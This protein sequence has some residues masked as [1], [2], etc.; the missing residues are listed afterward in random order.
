MWRLPDSPRWLISKSK[1][2]QARRV[3]QRV[4]TASD[5][6]PEITDIQQSMDTAEGDGGMAGL[7]Q[8]SLRMPMI[9]G[10][11][12]AVFQQITGINT[13]IYYAPT[14]FK[15]AGIHAA[16]S[17]DPGR[18]GVGHGDVVLSRAGH[19]PAGPRRKEAF[20]IGR[21][22]W[23]DYWPGDLWALAFQ[24]QQLASFKSDD[25]H[26]RPGDLCRLF[27]FWTRADLLADDF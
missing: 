22:C 24:F 23:S 11:G 16:G 27:R 6:S 8:P 1:V 7:F 2:E 18:S 5:V 15:F 20:V 3:L 14:I 25:R 17:G 21:S 26:W 4:R 9:V 12:L 19:L 10:V 13:V